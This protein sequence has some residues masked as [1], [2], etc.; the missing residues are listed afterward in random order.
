MSSDSNSAIA[1]ITLMEKDIKCGLWI[2]WRSSSF[3]SFIVP[4]QE[5]L[6][7]AWQLGLCNVPLAPSAGTGSLNLA[8]FTM[9]TSHENITELSWISN[10]LPSLVHWCN[11]LMR[12]EK[13]CLIDELL[14]KAKVCLDWEEKSLVKNTKKKKKSFCLPLIQFT[15]I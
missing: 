13:G 12:S 1:K 7:I 11:R 8:Y 2:L 10:T 4:Y 5:E 15:S 6:K 14:V 3:M 9:S